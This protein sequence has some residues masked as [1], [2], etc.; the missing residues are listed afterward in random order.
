MTPTSASPRG[1][2]AEVQAVTHRA[3]LDNSEQPCLI[4]D[5]RDSQPVPLL[6]A[7]HTW[8][9]DHLQPEPFYAEWCL[10][11]RWAMIRP[12]FRGPNRTPEACGSELAV[13]DIL[14][15]VTFARTTMKIDLNRIYLVGV[16]GG[17]HMALLMAGRA[18]EIWAG[19]SAWC[20]IHDL[21]AWHSQQKKTMSNTYWKALEA[22]CGGAPGSS[23]A[24]DDQYRQ[25]SPATW[26]KRA[27]GLPIDIAAGIADGHNGSVPVSH[28][29][30]AFNDL[31]ADTD[32]ISDTQI[33]AL[34]VRPSVPSELQRPAADPLYGAKPIL[35]R[36]QSRQARVT[37]FAGGHEIIPSAALNWLSGQ[38]KGSPA[39][40][41][42]AAPLTASAG[43]AVESG[44]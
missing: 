33:D 13:H 38:R 15:A 31:A 11:K 36:R 24:A 10:V 18:P 1:W 37:L 44:K 42:P 29:L 32:R 23:P 39:N 7:L 6:V 30:N 17:G 25:R 21:A 27:T 41:N 26:L 43:P 16:S 14:S 5:P 8:S 35:Y 19:V 2:P 3:G 20:G 28:S 22:V 40:W 12:N 4:Y 34:T 9:N